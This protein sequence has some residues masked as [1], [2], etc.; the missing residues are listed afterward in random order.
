MKR[1]QIREQLF[2]R[3]IAWLLVWSADLN[4]TEVREAA[5][6]LS[7]GLVSYGEASE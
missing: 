4:S 3:L 7:K 2:W 1:W 6:T 5:K